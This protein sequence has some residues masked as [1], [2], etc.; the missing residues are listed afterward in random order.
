MLGSKEIKAN[1]IL[2]F[3]INGVF[4]FFFVMTSYVFSESEP[5]LID[6]GLY[7]L[8]ALIGYLIIFT[9]FCFANKLVRFLNDQKLSRLGIRRWLISFLII[10]AFTLLFT[11]FTTFVLPAVVD[12]GHPFF[13]IQPF[14]MMSFPNFL[15]GL[16]I[17]G[18]AEMWNAFEENRDL[19][20]TLA[21]V[22]KEKVASQ[23]AALQQKINPH[24]LFNSLSVL[25]ELTY[26]DPE[27]ANEFIQEFA[28]VYRYV[29]DF[30]EETLVTV[31]KEMEFLEAYLFLL[32]IRF[33]ESL[34]IN[35]QLE[36]EV[37]DQ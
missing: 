1:A 15:L 6:I 19:Q 13:H 23:L 18:V 22:E 30:K 12:W 37:L 3:I 34:R 29:L 8:V 5:S 10:I 36:Q 35:N 2:A 21:N 25:S 11:K 33:G 20:L 4:M 27:K 28:K 26:D 9:A 17:F 31:K 32:K 24:F 7:M 14:L 16:V